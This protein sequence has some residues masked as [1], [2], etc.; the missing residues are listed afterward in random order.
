MSKQTR[1]PILHK[2]VPEFRFAALLVIGPHVAV[3]YVA[4]CRV[5]DLDAP[6]IIITKL[7]SSFSCPI[8]LHANLH[9]LSS[10]QYILKIESY[11]HHVLA[12]K[13]L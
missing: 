8:C 2:A 13:L 4:K 12:S 9:R 1:Q 3:M 10:H 11:T 6:V 5:Q 7:I